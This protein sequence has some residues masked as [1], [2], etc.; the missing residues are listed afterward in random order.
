M[1]G[2]ETWQQVAGYFDGDGNI[3]ISD[4]SNQPY[5]LGLSLIFTDQSAEQV[6][7]LKSF[8][9][10]HGV[11]TSN[12]LKTSKG[13]AHMI[14]VSRFESVLAALK[15]MLPHLF[16]KSNEIKGALDYYEGR[17][18]GNDLVALFSDEVKAG[19]R[20]RRD[21]K[22]AIDV[23]FTYPEGDALMKKRRRERIRAAI[24]KNRAKVS[25]KD[26]DVIRE[27]HF[28]LGRPLKELVR[29]YPQY[30]KETIR[31]I[32]GRGRGYVLISGEGLSTP[33]DR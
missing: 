25:R 27:T 19:R 28:D 5:K 3:S 9:E 15:A 2:Y 7:M 1:Q 14:A 6:L 17:I 26:Y 11:R 24:A 12:L 16:K 10:S 32:L 13:T 4:T 20:E 18:Q 29:A 21:R 33:L 8:L 23:P 31:R 22:V 30:S